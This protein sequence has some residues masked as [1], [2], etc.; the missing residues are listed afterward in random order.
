MIH[1]RLADERRT[2]RARGVSNA[3]RSECAHSV[4]FGALA[5]LTP[6]ACATDRFPLPVG[7]SVIRLAALATIYKNVST[8]RPFP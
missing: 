7:V 1:R 8:R 4:P 5:L 3:E 2:A 6:R